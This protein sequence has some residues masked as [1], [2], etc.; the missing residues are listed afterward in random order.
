MPRG[1]A[2]LGAGRPKGAISR[3]NT[4]AREAARRTGELPHQFLLRV[5]R[6][7]EIDGTVPTLNL[8]VDAAK[9]A[10]PYFAP[11][12]ASQNVNLFR[13]NAPLTRDELK[14]LAMEAMAELVP[15]GELARL[16]GL[17]GFELVKAKRP[18]MPVA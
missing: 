12:L 17:L 7:E 3:M 10:A 13:E 5:A 9:A 11:R 4:V 1:G 14:T 6:G 18:S 16:V 15:T 8:R 2:R